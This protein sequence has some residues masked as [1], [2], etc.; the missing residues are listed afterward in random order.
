[1][2]ATQ[3]ALLGGERRIAVHL[4]QGLIQFND[5]LMHQGMAKPAGRAID[6]DP[7]MHPVAGIARARSAIE[8]D[9]AVGAPIAVPQP[10]A[11]EPRPARYVEGGV[12]TGIGNCSKHLAPQRWL[13][14]FVAID[15]EDPVAAG[16]LKGT[17]LL[18]GIAGKVRRGRDPRARR[19]RDRE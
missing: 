2:S 14:P 5:R 19:L 10:P 18:C 8:P 15:G 6:D 17:L 9:D 12:T 1:M 7:I 4:L 11:A 16:E 3:E 13:D